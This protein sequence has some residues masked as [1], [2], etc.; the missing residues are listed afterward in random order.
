MLKQFNKKD[1]DTIMKI[2]K[3]NN[4]KFQGFIGSQYWVDNYI[5][6]K[7]EFLKNKIYI[8][9]EA[10]R[11]LAYIAVDDNDNIFDI[12]V[13][14]EI[15]REGIG[16]LLLEKVKKE[17][18]SLF[19]NVFEKNFGGV[20]F[21]KTAG[22]KKISEDIDKATEEKVY[23][24][25]WSSGTTLDST[26]IYFDNS[27]S[28][29]LL[30]KYDKS[31]NVQFYNISTY[32]KESSSA[33][34]IDISKDIEKNNGRNYVSDYMNV[35]NK[36]NSIIKNNSTFI[37]IDCNNDYSYLFNVIKD[38]AKVKGTKL[39]I[40]MHKP[41]SVEG[42]KKVKIYEDV[43]E[44]FKDFEVTDVDYEAIGENKEVTFKEA[45]DRRDEEMLKMVCN[46]K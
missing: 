27:I 4:Q 34:N 40:I 20:L 22:F 23:R 41:F 21:F 35:R 10:D 33:F 30:E 37:F 39:T 19:I 36:L 2:W 18:N 16:K 46:I 15:Q 5:Q 43:K 9:T 26:F 38:V 8:Y 17:H 3:D 11:I 45:F 1:I 28:E 29:E 14:P 32:A 6:T 44:Q 42:T 25:Q 24:M 13:K 7:E 12:Q 31:S